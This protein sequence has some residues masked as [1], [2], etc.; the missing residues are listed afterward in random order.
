MKSSRCQACGFVGWSESGNCK[1]CGSPI[2][3]R[4]QPVL[5]MQSP[6]ANYNPWSQPQEGQKKG[7]AI[8]SLVLGIIGFMTFG[9]IGFGAVVGIILAVVAMGKVKREPWK[10]GG[11]GIAT[12]GLV[13]N[14]VSLVSVVPIAIIAAIAIPNLLASRIAANE[15]AAIA[16]LRTVGSAQATYQAMYQ[17]FGTL[18]ELAAA[19]LI[20]PRVA[21]GSRSGYRFTLEITNGV[22]N[23]EGFELVAVPMSYKSSGRRSFYLNETMV[24]RGSDNMGGPSTKNDAP[25]DSNFDYTRRATRDY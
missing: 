12:A 25:L 11:H 10:Y 24:I 8:S 16:T 3:Q 7:L 4:P 2:I 22:D 17:K 21:G 23:S 5:Q 19:E 15:A 20:D 1:N 6:T 14:I 13:L 9:L 18:E